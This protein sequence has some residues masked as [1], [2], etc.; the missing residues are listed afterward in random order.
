MSGLPQQAAIAGASLDVSKV[1]QGDS[2]LGARTRPRSSAGSWLYVGEAQTGSIATASATTQSRENRDF[3]TFRR[4]RPN[5]RRSAG[6]RSRLALR[7]PF[8]TRPER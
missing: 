7:F 2:A 5:Q 8:I 1:P 3:A 6:L 4:K